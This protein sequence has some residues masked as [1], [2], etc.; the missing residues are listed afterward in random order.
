MYCVQTMPPLNSVELC[1]RWEGG[2]RTV[3]ELDPEFAVWMRKRAGFRAWR[4][5]ALAV[6]CA[7]LII[8]SLLVYQNTFAV[9]R[10]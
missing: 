3:R 7:C 1:E 4:S 2:A 6:L 9:F 8:F 10:W 5:V